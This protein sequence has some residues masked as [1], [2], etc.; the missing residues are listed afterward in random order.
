MRHNAR[1]FV[2]AARIQFACTTTHPPT[3]HPMHAAAASDAMHRFG[4]GDGVGLRF[5]LMLFLVRLTLAPTPCFI[6]RTHRERESANRQMLQYTCTQAYTHT[7]AC[8]FSKQTA[9]FSVAAL[10][11]RRARAPRFVYCKHVHCER[12]LT[13]HSPKLTSIIADRR[14]RKTTTTTTS[15][16]N[17]WAALSV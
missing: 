11:M 14:Q 17:R 12:K 6:F 1:A 7:R 16:K 5:S 13:R 8:L 10:P 4:G 3:L 2:M 15:S 9:L